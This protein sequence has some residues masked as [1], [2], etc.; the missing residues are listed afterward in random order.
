MLVFYH[1]TTVEA[2][3]AILADGFHDGTGS[4]MT[5]R[6]WSGVW[7]SDEPIEGPEARLNAVLQITFDPPQPDL[8]SYEWKEEGKESREWL[9]P[10]AIVNCARIEPF[11]CPT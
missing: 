8:S 1:R 4:Y 11:E 6:D 5:D 3:R 7:L 9:V 2:A 10:A